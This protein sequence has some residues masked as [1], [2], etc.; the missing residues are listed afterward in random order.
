MADTVDATALAAWL[1]EFARLVAEN[2]DLLTELDCAIGDADHGINLDRG[3]TAVVAA[4][5]ATHPVR[6]RSCSSGP[7]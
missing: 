7:G 5:T 6:R 2:R 4:W 3:M 1:R